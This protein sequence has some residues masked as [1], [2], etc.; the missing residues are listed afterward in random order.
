MKKTNPVI[1]FE[2]PVNNLE[3]AEQFYK[4]VFDFHFE[5]D[6]IDHYDMRLFPFD[7]SAQGISGALANGDVYKPTKEGI[8]IYFKTADIDKTLEK[9]IKQDGKILYPKTINEKYGFIVAEFEDSKGDRIAV[10]QF[11]EE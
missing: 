7:L 8:I 10:Q 5:K 6:S 2:I 3:R 1:Y 11:I 4:N 9:V